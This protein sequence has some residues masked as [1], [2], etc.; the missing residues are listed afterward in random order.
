MTINYCP[1][2]GSGNFDEELRKDLRK[3]R[4]KCSAVEHFL[5]YRNIPYKREQKTHENQDEKQNISQNYETWRIYT[6]NNQLI[7]EEILSRGMELMF[8][9][10]SSWRNLQITWTYKLR[11]HVHKIDI[12]LLFIVVAASSLDVI[13]VLRGL[14]YKTGYCFCKCRIIRYL[15]STKS[16]ESDDNSPRHVIQLLYSTCRIN[17]K[18]LLKFFWEI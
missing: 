9:G 12:F 18:W 10:L 1:L 14:D 11:V 15:P 8:S 3:M 13:T 2:W 5:L 7:E 16:E 4:K 6:G 17:N